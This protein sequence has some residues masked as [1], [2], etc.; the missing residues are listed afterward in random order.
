MYLLAVKRHCT[1]MV[2]PGIDFPNKA[3]TEEDGENGARFRQSL[4]DVNDGRI[5][6]LSVPTQSSNR[7]CQ[8]CQEQQAQYSDAVVRHRVFQILGSAAALMS[9]S[10][11]GSTEVSLVISAR[12]PCRPTTWVWGICTTH[13]MLKSKIVMRI[14]GRPPALEIA[15][16]AAL[17]PELRS[18]SKKGKTASAMRT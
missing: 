15:N 1:T 2:H 3:D 16:A 17:I 9:V 8:G 12:H 10:T 14:K 7:Q 4:S 5:V 11:H 18:G 6:R 13:M